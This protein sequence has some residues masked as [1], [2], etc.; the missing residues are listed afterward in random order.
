[1]AQGAE[2]LVEFLAGAQALERAAPAHRPASADWK[3]SRIRRQALGLIGAALAGR[4]AMTYEDWLAH[5]RSQ[6]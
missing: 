3:H 6:R 2:P 5:L 1:M 4:E